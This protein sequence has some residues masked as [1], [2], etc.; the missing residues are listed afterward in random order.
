MYANLDLYF[1]YKEV[2]EALETEMSNDKNVEDP[3]LIVGSRKWM[4]DDMG[5]NGPDLGFLGFSMME[6]VAINAKYDIFIY[7]RE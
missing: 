7:I 1:S 5:K 3:I 4:W 6:H 2:N